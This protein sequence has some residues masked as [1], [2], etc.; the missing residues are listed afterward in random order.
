MKKIYRNLLLASSAIASITLPMVSSSCNNKNKTEQNEIIKSIEAYRN[1]CQLYV[2][3]ANKYFTQVIIDTKN[4]NFL[5]PIADK[6][7]GELSLSSPNGKLDNLFYNYYNDIKNVNNFANQMQ[8]T[9]Q[10]ILTKVTNVDMEKPIDFYRSVLENHKS[11]GDMYNNFIQTYIDILG[12]AEKVN[13]TK[14]KEY[15]D[16]FVKGLDDATKV[17]EFSIVPV[18]LLQLEIKNYGMHDMLSNLNKAS[19]NSDEELRNLIKSSDEWINKWL[20]YVNGYKLQNIISNNLNISDVITELH[21]DFENN[22]AKLFYTKFMIKVLQQR[23]P[24]KVLDDQFNANPVYIKFSNSAHD[25]N[26]IIT[27][28]EILKQETITKNEKASQAI[29]NLEQNYSNHG[30]TLNPSYDINN[31]TNGLY[32]NIKLAYLANSQKEEAGGF[33]ATLYNRDSTTKKFSS[34]SDTPRGLAQKFDKSS[35]NHVIKFNIPVNV[36]AA[37]GLILSPMQNSPEVQKF[38]KETNG[39]LPFGIRGLNSVKNYLIGQDLLVFDSLYAGLEGN[40]SIINQWD[41][42]IFENYNFV[43]VNK[44]AALNVEAYIGINDDLYNKFFNNKSKEQLTSLIKDKQELENKQIVLED[45]YLPWVKN[46]LIPK[47]QINSN[48]TSDQYYKDKLAQILTNKDGKNYITVD[49]W[50]QALSNILDYLA[51]APNKD[52]SESTIQNAV[53]ELNDQKDSLTKKYEEQVKEINDEKAKQQAIV[54]GKDS[55]DDAKNNAKQAIQQLNLALD[56]AKNNYNKNIEALNSQIADA[57]VTIQEWIQKA[58]EHGLEINQ[59][60]DIEVIK[61][62]VTSI[63]N[64]VKEP[65]NQIQQQIDKLTDT[66]LLTILFRLQSNN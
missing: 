37:M 44:D 24:E 30:K 35:V 25:T 13:P 60:S 32:T 51:A 59:Y 39:Y 55:T 36:A 34:Q 22:V 28:N 33:A 65:I 40:R 57:K 56:T 5:A 6:F 11:I 14:A 54:D 29:K 45:K 4:D 49:K 41:Q 18:V 46:F 48:M 10:A 2:N 9:F 26:K 20:N 27:V 31:F 23:Q 19:K 15:Q 21:N 43:L 1:V 53:K 58:Q 3:Q 7:Y 17:F 63:L 64:T 12:Q 62:K 47:Y 52:Q 8:Q 66:E 50:M 61:N 38:F 16:K 42:L